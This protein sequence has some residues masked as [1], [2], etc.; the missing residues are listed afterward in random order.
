MRYT[1]VKQHDSTD[2]AAACLAMICLHYKKETSITQLRDIMGTDLKGTNLVGLSKCAHQL[3][4]N[5]QAV[6]VTN[7]QFKSKYSLPAIA[8]VVTKQGMLHFVVVF[9][10]TKT[11]VIIGDPASDLKKVPIDE[12]L[13]E[14]T[15]NMLIMVPTTKFNTDKG[16]KKS[17]F[18]RYMDLLKPQKK[19][20]FFVI[21]A[22]VIL[23]LLG[24]ASS[25]FNKILM[26]EI[27][28]YKLK[29]SLNVVIIIF[30]IMG[31]TQIAVG[32]VR[33][34]IMM[35]LSIKIDIP[36]KIAF[37]KY[38]RQNQLIQQHFLDPFERAA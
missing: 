16:D 27:L 4:F 25:M 22:S 18:S 28:P 8:H 10:I 5:S 23:T 17:I 36:L 2:C 20:F 24:I 3:G 29:N 15:G 33:Q 11:H 30:I 26:D 1:Y 31:F 21:L 6:K 12:F 32:F 7:E 13:E 35:H 37:L 38:F 14:F 9:K 34:W 19:L